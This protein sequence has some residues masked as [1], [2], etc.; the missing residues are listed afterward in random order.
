[1]G[2]TAI[3]E[4]FGISEDMRTWA[5]TKAPTVDIDREHES[6]V[7]YWRAHGTKMADWVATWRNWMRRAPQMGGA[8]KSP[9]AMRLARLS[10]EYQ[11]KGFRA[12]RQ[13][14]SS[15]TY[16][17]MFGRWH[18][19]QLPARDVVSLVARLRK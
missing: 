9:D 19:S 5:D 16:E 15:A 18:D 14:E 17:T 6:F 10:R 8:L 11:A 7:D 12:P 4:G 2:K 1:M 3:P 13:G